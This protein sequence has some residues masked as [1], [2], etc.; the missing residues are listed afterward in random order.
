MALGIESLRV[1]RMKVDEAGKHLEGKLP[2]HPGLTKRNPYA[3]LWDCIRQHLGRSYKDCE[4]HE[5][6][7][8]LE[9]IEY[10]K[11]NPS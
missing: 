1:I 11:N 5:V 4:E 6:P 10:Y 7:R 2:P 8:I 3:H 9:L